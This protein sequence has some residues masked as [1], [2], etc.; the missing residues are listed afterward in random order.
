LIGLDLEI[1]EQ[2][3]LHFTKQS[4]QFPAFVQ[5]R[6]RTGDRNLLLQR[7][8]IVMPD[9]KETYANLV[10]VF[11]PAS[12]SKPYALS[13]SESAKS[14][15]VGLGGMEIEYVEPRSSESEVAQFLERFGPGVMAIVFGARDPERIVEKC[16]ARHVRV[17]EDRS[18][19]RW[20]VA[21]RNIVG[22]DIVLEKGR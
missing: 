19:R 5:P 16:K 14:F 9:I 20:L 11:A 8:V 15:R 4:V 2:N 3:F 18:P 13:E 17:T 7:L 12:R 22:F 6:P 1:M 10:K 21:S